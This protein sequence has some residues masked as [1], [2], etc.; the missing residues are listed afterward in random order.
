MFAPQRDWFASFEK[1]NCNLVQM[2]DEATCS[3]D[4]VGTILIKI[5]DGMVREM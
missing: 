2:G 5:F 1:L 4:G 3:M